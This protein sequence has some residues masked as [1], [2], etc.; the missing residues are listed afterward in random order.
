MQTTAQFDTDRRGRIGAPQRASVGLVLVFC[1]AL[2][3]GCSDNDGTI[4]GGAN[5]DATAFDGFFGLSDG[6]AAGGDGVNGNPTGGLC[7]F[8]SS[9]LAGQPGASCSQNSDCDSNLCVDGPD[10]HIC[11]WQ[12]V[13][14]CPN[15]FICGEVPNTRD[16]V[17][18]CVPHLLSLCRPCMEDAECAGIDP[19]ALC[20]GYGELGRF[21]AGGCD[22]EADCPVGYA[23][24]D[25]YGTTGSGKQC[26]RTQGQC[27]CSPQSMLDAAKTSCATSNSVGSCEG[28]RVCGVG[29]LS[30]CD[31]PAAVA[32]TCNGADD[33][34]NG[35]TD[36][37]IAATPCQADNPLGSCGGEAICVDGK[38]DCQAQVP[39]DEVCDGKD[40]D[41]NG[42]TDEGEVDTNSDGQADCVDP[43]DDGDGTPDDADCAP[44]DDAIHPAAIEACNGKDDNCDGSTDEG[45][46]DSDADGTPDCLDTDKDD[47][48]TPDALDCA[49][50]DGNIHPGATEVCN[51]KDD[52]CDGLT[53]EKGSQGCDV[54]YAD[55]DG[56]GWGDKDNEACLC[57]PSAPWTVLIAGDCNDAIKAVSPAATEACEGQDTDCDGKTDEIGAT[58]CSTWWKD[59]DKDGFGDPKV[60][61]C[62][63]GAD[64][65]YTVQKGADCD[66]DHD[67]VK[68][69]ASELCD[70]LDN[71]CN[72]VT[73]E[74][75]ALGGACLAGQGGCQSQGAFVCSG[76]GKGVVCDAQAIGSKTEICDDADNDCDGQTDEGCDVD[77]DGWCD[78]GKQTI[79]KP[80]VCPN[81][82]GDCSDGVKAVHPGAAESCNG[83][84]DDCDGQTDG[85]SQACASE[86][87]NGSETCKAGVWQGCTAPKPQCTSG[88]CCDGCS[89]KPASTKCGLSP[90][91]T[92]KDCSGT[93][94]G[95]IVL[96]EQWQYCSG[97]SQTCGS[98]NLKWITKGT[99]QTCGGSQ[100]CTD[101]GANA[102]CKT[103]ALGCASGK[104]KT[105]PTYTICV[106]AGYGGSQNGVSKSGVYEKNLDLSF[107]KHLQDWLVKDTANGSGGGTWNVVMTRTSDVTV[108]IDARV[109][110]CNNA[111]SHRVLSIFTNWYSSTAAK[112]A[113]TW[114]WK[115][116]SQASKDFA[117]KV[118]YWVVNKGVVFS[119]GVK[120]GGYQILG[121]VNAPAALTLPGFLS[122]GADF[123]KLTS[124]AWRKTVALGMLHA[125]QESFGYTKFQP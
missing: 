119:R 99:I 11:T 76:D 91:A 77:G 42:L 101:T 74:G 94:G 52:N 26:V 44:L 85:M 14:C 60:S 49:P 111:G 79:G 73:D 102:T 15:G 32:E 36:D 67:T 84:D 83:K 103:C 21:C 8:P 58:N 6:M 30:P 115:S 92:N 120:S 13:D 97:A 70:Q 82:G 23:C 108:S 87:G 105:Q 66:D 1:L 47:D 71:D 80:A 59:A 28:V 25:S 121:G 124:D 17:F 16:T 46:A 45:F 24:T 100:L 125:I 113:E 2:C 55:A 112:G 69:G 98:S 51:G 53:D 64:A 116:P 106:D 31:A 56:D 19:G 54:Y 65:T 81:G 63:C 37:Q 12:C 20:V 22:K 96:K 107:A 93:C 122:N 78:A 5:A 114:V 34:C 61:A 7:E 10:G 3:A 27:A 40:N 68:P 35:E 104:C 75:F 43:D 117:A 62:A 110:K 39:G 88:P 109:A 33:D 18:A 4:G 41:C 50:L 90:A 9:P 38:L 89:Y 72:S 57:D 48:G 29:G 95:G 123:T 86:C 118:Q